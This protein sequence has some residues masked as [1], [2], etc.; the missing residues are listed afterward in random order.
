MG[1]VLPPEWVLRPTSP[2]EERLAV[3]WLEAERSGQRER[4][5][6]LVAG[7]LILLVVVL[8]SYAKVT[9]AA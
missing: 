8:L 6:I 5:A 7:G 4:L 3:A 1:Y 9:C 2:E